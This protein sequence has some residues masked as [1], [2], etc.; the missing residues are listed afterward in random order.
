VIKRSD[1]RK[2]VHNSGG[3]GLR[4][5]TPAKK[6]FVSA[7]AQDMHCSSTAFPQPGFA[8][9]VVR[10]AIMRFSAHAAAV[11]LWIAV[12]TVSAAGATGHLAPDVEIPATAPD[13]ATIFRVFLNDGSSLVSYGEPAR[14]G[15]RIVFSMPTTANLENPPLHL[16][17]LAAGQVDWPRTERYAEAA[18]ASKYYASVAEADYAALTDQVAAALTAVASATDPAARLAIV[19]KARRTLADWPRTHFHYREDEIR[20]MLGMLDEIVAE[21]RAQSGGAR[22][23]L[24]FVARSEAPA[25]RES[26]LPLPTPKETV[27]QVLVAAR[28]AESPAERLSLLSA[29]IGA[30]ERDSDRL[31]GDWRTE[32]RIT[33]GRTL[34]AELDTERQYQQLT[35]RI[36]ALASARSNAA[37]VRGVERLKRDVETTDLQLGQK[38]PDVISGLLVSLE[39]HLDAARALRL[40]HDRWELRSADF[41][42]YG[43][44]M[45]GPL[46]RLERLQTPL[47]DIKSLV[48]SS[49]FALSAILRGADQA[50]K[51]LSAIVPP[52][53]FRSVHALFLSAAHLADTAA[54][55][56]MEAALTGDLRRAWDASSAAAGALMLEAQA[57][58]EFKTLFQR[59]QLTK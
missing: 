40:A 42:A 55:I 49:P 46:S 58:N 26:L 5:V 50:T 18:R 12:G 23:D 47:G 41:R 15:D 53:E 56:R 28:L 9:F 17:N 29:A 24:A 30:L 44:Q 8:V 35:A 1:R 16:V 59:P 20:P 57:R 7:G 3:L 10:C 43:N 34:A 51:A 11:C 39:A 13:G 32:T 45:T 37:D 27:E 22:F 31:P 4:N 36:L 19:E 25:A 54:K 48:G 21:L 2:A 6:F 52:D 33:L 38:R 14:V